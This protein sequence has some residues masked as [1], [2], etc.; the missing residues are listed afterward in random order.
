M[1]DEK[2]M[3]NM[4]GEKIV[5]EKPE[6]R[7]KIKYAG[8]KMPAGRNIQ[9][10]QDGQLVKEGLQPVTS[11]PTQVSQDQ[12]QTSSQDPSPAISI[13]ILSGRPI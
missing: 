13:T 8:Q 10:G 7:S 3:K 4:A 1:S 12:S 6:D 11:T 2:Q 5:I 9:A